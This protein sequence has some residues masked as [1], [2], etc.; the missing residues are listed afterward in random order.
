M[1]AQNEQEKTKGDAVKADSDDQ[2]RR[3][4]LKVD[5]Q[6]RRDKMVTDALIKDASNKAQYGLAADSK[7]LD[8]QLKREQ[9]MLTMAQQ[10]DSHTHEV[11]MNAMDQD[12]EREMAE[13]QHQQAL[14]QG[15]QQHA[16]GMEQNEQQAALAPP[17][18]SKA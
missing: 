15:E 16:Q 11:G 8:A 12:H 1:L 13:T 17:P 4:K 2:F 14:E 18:A 6:F 5:D 7:A 3:E 9:A 10:H